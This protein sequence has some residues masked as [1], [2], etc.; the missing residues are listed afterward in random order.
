MME[1]WTAC[2]GNYF[3]NNW[4]YAHEKLC[5]YTSSGARINKISI[6]NRKE[7][8]I[9]SKFLSS[10]GEKCTSTKASIYEF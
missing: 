6:Q 4:I 9:G 5:Q 7:Y 10:V 1:R 8:E 2:G 3:E